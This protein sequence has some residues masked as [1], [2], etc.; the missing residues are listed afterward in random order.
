MKPMKPLTPPQETA[1]APRAGKEL[2]DAIARAERLLGHYGATR[3]ATLAEML[4]RDLR[5]ARAARE[6]APPPTMRRAAEI[7]RTYE[8]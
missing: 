5:R 6:G 7:L 8:S 1:R 3:Q 4:A 2:R